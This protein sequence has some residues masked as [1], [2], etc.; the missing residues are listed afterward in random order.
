V[1]ILVSGGNKVNADET[2][3]DIPDNPKD[4]FYH[5]VPDVEA[6]DAIKHLK[7]ASWRV[8]LK[9]PSVH[10]SGY[11]EIPTSYLICES[12]KAIPADLQRM[13]LAGND[14]EMAKRGSK[15]RIRQ[16][17]VDASHSPF[18]S[19]PEKTADFIRRSAGEDVSL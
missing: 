14:E 17:V 4:L 13:M 15:L 2:L 8:L 9:A 19:M 3:L 7:P 5:D 12:D 11:W 10:G 16:E 1:L 6:V 18:L